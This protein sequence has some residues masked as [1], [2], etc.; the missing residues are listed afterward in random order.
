MTDVIILG[1]GIAGMGAAWALHRAGARVRVLEARDALGGNA[2]THTWQTEQGPVTTGLSVLAWPTRYFRNYNALL[3]TLAIPTCD[4][5]LRMFVDAPSGVFQQGSPPAVP[6]CFENDLSRWEALVAKARTVNRWFSRTD[7]PSF[8]HMS[9]ANPLN[10]LPLRRLMR[11]YGISD[12][13]FFEVLTAVHATS[14]LT[15][16]LTRLP[17]SIAPILEDVMPLAHG[18]TMSTWKGSSA[19]VFRAMSAGFEDRIHTGARAASVK[20]VGVGVVVEDALG[21][22]HSADHVIF[23]CDAPTALALIEAPGKLETSLLGGVE[24]VEESDKTFLGGEAHGDVTMLPEAYRDDLLNRCCNYVRVTRQPD[25][26]RLRYENTFVISS[27]YPRPGGAAAPRATPMLVTYNGA[28]QP[29][30]ALRRIDNRRAHPAMNSQNLAIVPA[31]RR[32][33]GRAGRYYCGSYTTPGNG[34]DLSLLSGLVVAERL[35]APHPFASDPGAKADFDRLRA[36]MI[37]APS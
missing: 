31:L 12:A 8:Y 17:A 28:R 13:F 33:Q 9:L 37:G 7:E 19:E 20:N 11:S 15:T 16:D 4:V 5:T 14:F 1:A 6:P 36:L 23:A 10:V 34:H 29:K 25:T 22:A 24:Y 35:G 30:G 32:I 2:R 18:A 27:W 26:R 3:R 21:Q